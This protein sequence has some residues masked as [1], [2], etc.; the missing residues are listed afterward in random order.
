MRQTILTPLFSLLC[1]EII[2]KPSTAQQPPSTPQNWIFTIL[3]TAQDG[4]SQAR[5]HIPTPN[6][7]LPTD[8]LLALDKPQVSNITNSTFD[9]WYFDAVSDTDPRES[10]VVTFFAAPATAFP[11]IKSTDS[12]LIAYIWATFANGSIFAR[13]Q[14]ATL[15]TVSGGQS[16][17]SP[18]AGNW[19]STGFSWEALEDDLSRYEVVIASTEMGVHGRFVLSSVRPCFMPRPAWLT[20]TSA[21]C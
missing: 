17:H 7:T 10:L 19:S 2:T 15:A 3:P 14:P 13:Y 9:W 5:F 18:S 11:F 20:C 8:S 4:P 12:V 6:Q 21:L 16:A 1:I